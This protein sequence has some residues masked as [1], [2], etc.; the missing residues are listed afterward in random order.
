MH[1][2]INREKNPGDLDKINPN[3]KRFKKI[4]H[5]RNYFTRITPFC[6]AIHGGD[7]DDGASPLPVAR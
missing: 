3:L 1:K 4:N 2:G 6:F 5:R 7:A